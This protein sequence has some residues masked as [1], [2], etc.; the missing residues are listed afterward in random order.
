M[1]QVIAL[2]QRKGGVSISMVAVAVAVG[3]GSGLPSGGTFV[4][5]PSPST[6][7]ASAFNFGA[8]FVGLGINKIL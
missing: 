5:I 1:S 6:G 8:F 2:M 4:A 3:T 7:G